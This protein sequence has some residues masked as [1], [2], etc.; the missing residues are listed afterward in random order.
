VVEIWSGI[1]LGTRGVEASLAGALS[2]AVYILLAEH[3]VATRDPISLS[4]YGFFFASLFWAAV[5]PWSSFPDGVV[6]R[7][8][9]P[10]VLW[11]GESPGLLQ[12]LGGGI[13]LAAVGPAQSSR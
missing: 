9:S 5:Q 11:L 8:T 4:C 12:L 3:A 2:Y 7:T 1:A 6:G 10:H 13:V